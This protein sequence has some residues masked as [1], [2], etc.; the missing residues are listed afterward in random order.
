MNNCTGSGISETLIHLE[1]KAERY[2]GLVLTILTYLPSCE[3]LK[4]MKWYTQ[5]LPM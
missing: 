4:F 3:S 5:V 1:A 2:L